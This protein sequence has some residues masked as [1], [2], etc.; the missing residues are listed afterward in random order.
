MASSTTGSREPVN[1]KG[2]FGMRR[3]MEI[4]TPLGDGALLFH[5]MQAREELSR[6]SEFDIELLGERGDIDIDAILGKNVTVKLE[7]LDEGV[8]ALIASRCNEVESGARV[9]DAILTNTVLPR[10]SQEFLA[11]LVEGRKVERVGLAARGA[12]FEYVFD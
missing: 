5:R 6:L 2:E 11:R 9:I 1:D 7:Q 3:T 8:V 12:E 10:I 4:V